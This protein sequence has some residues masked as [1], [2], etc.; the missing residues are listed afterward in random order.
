MTIDPD[1]VGGQQGLFKPLIKLEAIGVLTQPLAGHRPCYPN[2]SRSA[3]P[4]SRQQ[5][6]AC[7]W[8]PQGHRAPH[9]VPAV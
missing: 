7:R 9:R 3:N 1:Q 4:G 5:S 8:R 6:G 2:A